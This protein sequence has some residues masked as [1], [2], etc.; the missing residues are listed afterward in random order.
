MKSRK[1]LGRVYNVICRRPGAKYTIYNEQLYK[2][3]VIP[4]NLKRI[5]LR[6]F[7]YYGNV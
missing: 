4:L 6:W 7:A 1:K 2:A 5:T 3:N